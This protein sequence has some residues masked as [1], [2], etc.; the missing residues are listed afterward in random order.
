M[1]RHMINELHT[2]MSDAA[3]TEQEFVYYADIIRVAGIGHLSGGVLRRELGIVLY[4]VN[5][6]ER[7]L[8]VGRPILSAIAVSSDMRPGDGFYG[9]AREYGVLDS[10]DKNAELSFWFTEL[11]ALRNYWQSHSQTIFK[12]MTITYDAVRQTLKE[13]NDNYPNPN[14][15]DQWLERD[16][17][18]YALEFGGRLYPPK[19]I[20]SEITGFPITDFSGG[21]QTNRVFE[22]LGMVIVDKPATEVVES[23]L[24]EEERAVIAQTMELTFR[25][26]GKVLV[27]SYQYE[28]DARARKTCI[29][30][31]GFDCHV[32][33]FNFGQEFGEI[34]LGFI[35]VHH[36]TPVS[37]QDGE[38][39]IDPIEDLRPVCPNCHAM[40]HKQTPPYSIAE[41]QDIR[42]QTARQ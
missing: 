37:Q 9:L 38:H 10:E 36:L 8:A 15:Y 41:L 26:G 34:G 13:F 22:Q 33:G 19:Y 16:G 11:R 29:D 7:A 35:H 25:E 40:L 14:D 21:D 24:S 5:E 28:R 27:S 32:C 4:E 2:L 31:Y 1:K 20:L 39:E 30:H 12:G 23:P 3:R 18:K 6:Y 42:K 17:Y